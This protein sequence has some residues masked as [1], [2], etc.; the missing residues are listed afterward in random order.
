MAT[1]KKEMPV[2]TYRMN[3]DENKKADKLCRKLYK[4]SLSTF[5]RT[6]VLNHFPNAKRPTSRKVVNG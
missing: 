3:A 4:V 5:I 2:F 6:M 1:N